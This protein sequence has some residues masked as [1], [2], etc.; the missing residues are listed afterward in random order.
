MAD[1][2]HAHGFVDYTLSNWD[3][4]L[5]GSEETWADKGTLV[6]G[7]NLVRGSLLGRITTGGKYTL[8][9]SASSDGSQVPVAILAHD[10]D[11]TSADKECVVYKAGTF[12]S[13]AVTLGTGIVLDTA[14][15]HALRGLDIHFRANLVAV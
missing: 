6:S 14:T 3:N 2:I 9:L 8:A 13:N 7:Q 10:C 12:N 1:E 15:R 11:A 5:A 4:L